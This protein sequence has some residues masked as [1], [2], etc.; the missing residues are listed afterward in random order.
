MGAP[1]PRHAMEY[2][3]E[4]RAEHDQQQIRNEVSLI[5]GAITFAQRFRVRKLSHLCWRKYSVPRA[6]MLGFNRLGRGRFE[7]APPRSS[8]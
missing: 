2:D 4:D 7:L 1:F 6:D 3:E 8:P 5:H